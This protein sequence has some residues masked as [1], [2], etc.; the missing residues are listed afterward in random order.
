MKRQESQEQA[1]LEQD[2]GVCDGSD[3]G[4]QASQGLSCESYVLLVCGL[5]VLFVQWVLMTFFMP[6]FALSGPG[7]RISASVQGF[8]FASFPAGTA[9]AA[10]FI[11]TL[12][13][14]F[15]TRNT[16]V[17]GLIFMSIFV[18]FFGIVPSL[19]VSDTALPIVLTLV[20]FAYGAFSTLAE[21]GTYAILTYTYPDSLGKVFA[22]T[23]IMVGAGSTLGP[24]FGGIIY[25]WLDGFSEDQQFMTTCAI[26]GLVPLLAMGPILRF[27]PN[28]YINEGGEGESSLSEVFTTP[29]LMT[30][31]AVFVTGASFTSI[32]PTMPIRLQNKPFHLSVG[33]TGSI[34]LVGGIVYMA[35]ATP[36]GIWVDRQTTT[37]P[38]RLVM[39]GGLFALAVGFLMDGPFRLGSALS[40][41]FLDNLPSFLGGQLM[42]GVGQAMLLIPCLPEMIVAFPPEAEALRATV[43][44]L[45]MSAY[46]LG[47]VSGPI[48]ATALMDLKVSALCRSAD[49]PI[50]NATS[51]AEEHQHCFDGFCTVFTLIYFFFGFAMLLHAVVSRNRHAVLG[52]DLRASF[53]SVASTR[54]QCLATAHSRAR[55]VSFSPSGAVGASPMAASTENPLHLPISRS[56]PS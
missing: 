40:F 56:A 43:T 31:A 2:S 49:W 36:L 39:A 55:A 53:A 25:D 22:A 5:L 33:S 13:I 1:L 18:I 47:S 16:V 24:V 14:R 52:T 46:A 45:Q 35:L 8:I 34:F 23:E 28:S 30:C 7:S 17:T 38:M 44:G 41:D 4:H 21:T 29:V 32:S 11:S 26:F 20:G 37:T 51:D 3:D 12:L 42:L 15:G 54:S 27:M 48:T 50:A 9:V 19:V 10:P 6:F